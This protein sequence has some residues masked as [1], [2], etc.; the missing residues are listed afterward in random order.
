MVLG[1]TAG[2]R[3]R[4]EKDNLKRVKFWLIV[5]INSVAV[6]TWKVRYKFRVAAKDDEFVFFSLFFFIVVAVLVLYVGPFGSAEPKQSV[7]GLLGYRFLFRGHAWFCT[8]K[9]EA[10]DV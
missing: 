4:F 2:A 8:C 7:Q 1:A 3:R 9:T 6:K 10:T 5:P